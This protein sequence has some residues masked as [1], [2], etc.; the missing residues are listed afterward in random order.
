MAVMLYKSSK[1]NEQFLICLMT[2]KTTLD[3]RR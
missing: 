2:L 1:A 3:A